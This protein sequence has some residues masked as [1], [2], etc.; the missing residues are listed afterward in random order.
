[1][2]WTQVYNP[3]DNIWLSAVFAALPVIFFFL[4]L[5]LFKIKGHLAAF[6]TLL[7]SVAIALLFYHMPVKMAVGAA[8][9]GAAYAIWP[10]AYIVIGAVFLYKI[11][12]KSGQ[13]EIIRQ[14][15]V[16]LTDDPRVQMLLVGF[17]F[18][19][20]LEGAAGFGAPIA[21]TAALLVGLGFDPIKA[22]GLCLIANVAPGSFGAIGI[23]I[24]VAGQVSGLAPDVISAHL[25]TFMPFV[26]F[27]IPFLLISIMS[28]LKGIK[29][30]WRPTLVTAIAYSFTQFLTIR[31]IGPELPDITSAIV[32]LIVL[33]C[34]LKMSQ[35]KQQAA[36]HA[37]TGNLSFGKIIK[38]WSPFI[39]LTVFVMIWC[40][41]AFKQLFAAGGMLSWTT[42]SVPFPW[43]NNLVVK[44]AP[45]VTQPTPYA[46]VLKLDLISATG[47]AIL[48]SC[49][50][51]AVSLKVHFRT[52][53]EIFAETLK[54]LN[55]PILTIMLVLS[56]AFVSNYS[57][58]S[59]TMGIALARTAQYFP[60]FSPVLGWL[61]VF[62]TGSVVSANALFGGLQEITANQIG[63]LPLVLIAANVGGGTMAKMLSPQSI[64]IAAG[65]VGIAGKESSLFRFTI[66]YSVVLL[67]IICAVA[68]VQSLIY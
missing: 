16:S 44:A 12:V 41:D 18:N 67:V 26:S 32:S 6:Y 51:A 1:M 52:G 19:S 17:I 66:K 43:L 2:T 60:M 39:I 42:V 15:I 29:E 5:T 37:S 46:A 58:Q 23:P 28:S 8:G 10:I 40:S 54:E 36:H 11:T 56:F 4:S 53:L 34:Y 21:I 24:V 20:F 31:F 62:L 57:G 35:K 22:A 50:V 61:G 55:K 27:M 63:V 48:L 9:F 68:F 13:F 49:V 47:T 3:A 7:L 25:A 45:L 59:S 33:A 65:A 38:G 30:V 64:A 14:S